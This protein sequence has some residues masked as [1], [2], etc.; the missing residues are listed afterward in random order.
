MRSGKFSIPTPSLKFPYPPVNSRLNPV[1]YG[2]IRERL[3]EYTGREILANDLTYEVFIEFINKIDYLLERTI[4]GL[5]ER[6]IK[7]E[8]AKLNEEMEIHVRKY[9]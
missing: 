4:F 9:R 3:R 6:I 2:K 7:A 5:Q 8:K 1:R